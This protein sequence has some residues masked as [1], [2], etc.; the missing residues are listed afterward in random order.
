MTTITIQLENELESWVQE[1]ARLLG[2][3]PEE[4]VRDTLKRRSLS[5]AISKWRSIFQPMAEQAGITMEED[6][7]KLVKEMREAR[8]SEK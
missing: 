4:V 6:V 1:Q 3:T 5:N 8:R 7:T 2:K